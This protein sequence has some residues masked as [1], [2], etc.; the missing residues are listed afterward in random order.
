MKVLKQK[1]WNPF[2]VGGLI[3]LLSWFTLFTA[4]HPLGITSTFENTAALLLRP[5]AGGLAYFSSPDNQPKIDWEWSLVL[6]V[7]IGAFISSKFSHDRPRSF[8]P[9]M[10]E[11]RFGYNKNKRIWMAFVGGMIMMYGARLAQGCTSGH[12]ISGIMQ[13]AL[14]SWIFVPTFAIAGIIT[15]RIIYP[16]RDDV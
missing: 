9:A 1:S 15:A 12:G 5:L 10:W 13:F 8:L 7:F 16:R 14:S 3:A 11:K 6:G 4:D 2:V